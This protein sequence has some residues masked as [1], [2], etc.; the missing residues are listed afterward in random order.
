MEGVVKCCYILT[1]KINVQSIKSTPS[2]PIVM[3][4]KTEAINLS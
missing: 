2:S 4:I 3:M 1:N